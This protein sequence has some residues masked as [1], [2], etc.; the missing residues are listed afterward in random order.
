MRIRSI[1]RE[2]RILRI[3]A[4]CCTTFATIALLGAAAALRSVSFDTITAHRLNIVDRE[5]KLAMVLA[6]HDDEALPVIHGYTPSRLGR[7]QGNHADNGIVFFN[8]KGD[9]QGALVWSSS[10]DRSE[11]G[12]TLSFD[13]ANT[14]QLMHVEDGDDNG[15]HYVAVI[16]WDR[17]ADEEEREVPLLQ[18]YDAATTAAQRA[19]VMQQFRSLPGAQTRFYLGYDRDDVS[20]LVLSDKS[21]KP[22]VKIFVTPDGQAKMQFLDANGNVTYEVPH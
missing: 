3:Y 15:H 5:G 16:G 22:R 20:Q 12:D 10:A 1:R 9:E 11:S 18:A 8:Q 6:S 14:D 21:G 19:A 17:A 2:I 13:T 4:L 7:A